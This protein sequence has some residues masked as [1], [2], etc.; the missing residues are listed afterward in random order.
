M[1]LYGGQHCSPGNIIVKQRG[2]QFHPGVHVG[3]VWPQLFMLL[4]A[5]A[6]PLL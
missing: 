4:S 5:W 2:T 1:K 6:A 3:M